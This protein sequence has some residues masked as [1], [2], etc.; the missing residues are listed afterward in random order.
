MLQVSTGKFFKHEAYE[1]LRRAIYY[2]NYRMFRDERLDT[3]VGSLQSV[4]GVHGL[5]A[6]TCEI[7]ERIQK[8]PGGPYPGEVFATSG[9]TL[10]NDFAAIVSFAL[11]VTCTTDLELARRLVSSER[12][13]LGA[14]LVP[15]KY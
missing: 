15:Q 13:S 4:A 10:I 8:L 14:D 2:T 6:L 1:T 11:S 3:Q 7:I 12:P 9:D 5:G